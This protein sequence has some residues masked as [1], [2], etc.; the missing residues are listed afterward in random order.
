MA[1]KSQKAKKNVDKKSGKKV[2]LTSAST[3]A[4]G[5][6]TITT[7]ITP[8]NDR[9]LL[10]ELPEIATTRTT[11]SGFIVPDDASKDTGGKRGKVVAVGNGR[12]EHGAHIPVSVSVGDTVLYQWGGDKISL[13]GE[14][15]IIVRESEII[16]ILNS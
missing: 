6:K 16:A 10:Q 9:V 7:P 13:N 2:A 3:T 14:E 15:Y 4:H 12:Y 8:L 5:A 1:K 11:A